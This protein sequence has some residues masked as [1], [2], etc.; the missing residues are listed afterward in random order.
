M[1]ESGVTDSQFDNENLLK[2]VMNLFA[3]GTDTSGITLR[4]LL[5]F[6][7]KYPKIQGKELKISTKIAEKHTVQMCA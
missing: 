1:Q 4:W 6:M 3:A 2:T 5:L 7:A